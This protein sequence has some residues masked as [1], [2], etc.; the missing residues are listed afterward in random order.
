[1]NEEIVQEQNKLSILVIDD[2]PSTFQ[3][4]NRLIFK[5]RS[6]IPVYGASNGI[7]GMLK[8]LEL[9][10]S[11]VFVD[12]SMPVMDGIELITIVRNTPKLADLPIVV[13][14]AN[15]GDAI[16]RKL[17]ELKVVDYILKP[18]SNASVLLRIKELIA[19][20]GHQVNSSM[21]AKQVEEKPQKK[22][23]LILENNEMYAMCIAKYIGANYEPILAKSSSDFINK[24][25]EAKPEIAVIGSSSYVFHNEF[26]Y[27]KVR[28]IIEESK[29]KLVV[30]C[31]SDKDYMNP[32]YA[33][34][35]RIKK[36]E[37]LSDL[38]EEIKKVFK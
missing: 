20:Y 24:F 32:A 1:M 3:L 16:V 21:N 9:N 4:M 33:N 28:D 7:E 30:F 8:I 6:N 27:Q 25:I 35:V 26:L 5:V 37:N 10:P 29:S 34:E 15:S 22:G 13:L 18:F 38:E 19:K 17:A 23:V 31:D 12:L 2:S 11:I 14:S 36:H